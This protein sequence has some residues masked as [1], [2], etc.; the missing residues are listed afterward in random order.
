[1]H[2]LT[3]DPAARALALELGAA[4]AG[5]AADAP[6][7]PLDAAICFAPAGEL[8]PVAL[9]ALAPGGTLAVAG[10]H[11]SEIP[12]L[13]YQRHVFRERTLTS[14]TSNTRA[15]GEALLRLASRLGVRATVT[16]YP[17]SAADRALA[18]LAGD[19]VRGAAVL[20]V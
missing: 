9:A 4:S 15:D 12:A 20:T 13:D 17:L 18:D 2:V 14:V 11:L 7:V 5:G 16:G 8:V 6:P 10:I 1:V 3:R 19:R